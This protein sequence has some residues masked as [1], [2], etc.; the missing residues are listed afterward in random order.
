[1]HAQKRS[2]LLVSI[3]ALGLGGEAMACG[4]TLFRAGSSMRQHMQTAQQPARILILAES[5]SEISE[6][7]DRLYAGLRRAGHSVDEVGDTEALAEA[8]RSAEYDL[9]LARQSE[10]PAVVSQ[11]EGDPSEATA[12][13]VRRP[14]LIPV[15]AEGQRSLEPFK[16]CVKQG[17]EVGAFLRAIARAMRDA[18]G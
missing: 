7:R 16:V 11:L 17:A 3:I 18:P 2:W 13:H 8:L 15:L 9:V 14:T 1:M 12:A 5:D 6:E 10:V 4:E